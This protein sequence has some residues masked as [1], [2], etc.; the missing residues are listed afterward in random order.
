MPAAGRA[1]GSRQRRCVAGL[2]L[3]GVGVV[4]GW[5]AIWKSSLDRVLRVRH[6]QSVTFEFLEILTSWFSV[7]RSGIADS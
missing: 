5:Q 4:L 7:F 6:I 2:Q 3:L 1:G